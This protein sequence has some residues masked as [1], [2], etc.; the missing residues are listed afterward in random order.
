MRTIPWSIGVFG[1]AAA[2]I[3]ASALRPGFLYGFGIQ[4]LRAADQGKVICYI[5][6]CTALRHDF[7][8]YRLFSLQG[9]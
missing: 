9:F 3:D 1:S 5:R 4:R 8:L 7:S 6:V 2:F